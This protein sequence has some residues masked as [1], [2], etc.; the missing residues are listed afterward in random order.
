MLYIL[1]NLIVIFLMLLGISEIFY[2][3]ARIIFK[4]AIKPK[5]Y[6]ILY[7]DSECAEQQILS[8]LFNMRWFGE[9]FAKKIIFITKSL[10]P[11]Q[12]HQL[13][14]EYK[15]EIAEFKSGVFNE[16]K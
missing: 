16:Y 13:E 10:E 6:L 8:E 4:P 2:F 5:K 7:L 12:A 14:K 3:L 9:R 1:I 11:T 15:S